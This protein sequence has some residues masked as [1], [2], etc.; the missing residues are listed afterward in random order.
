MKG[1]KM[2][3]CYSLIDKVYDMG[4]LRAAYKAVRANNGAPGIDG[5]TVKAFGEDLE[6]RLL[7]IHQRLKART[8]EPSP[9][10][11]WRSETRWEQAS[12]RDPHCR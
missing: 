1:P 6:A 7:A 5:E 4:N 3:K 11:R 2:K 8:Y 12:A 10:R 9:V